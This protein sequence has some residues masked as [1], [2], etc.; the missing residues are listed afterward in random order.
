MCLGLLNIGSLNKFNL[1]LFTSLYGFS[2]K[3]IFDELGKL[4]F[5]FSPQT[6]CI[7]FL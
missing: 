6:I 2:N 4:L 1:L 7:E 5:F 3:V